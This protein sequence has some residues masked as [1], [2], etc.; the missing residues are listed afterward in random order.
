MA[1]EHGGS[2]RRE[3]LVASHTPDAI[4]ARLA[5]DPRRSYLGDAV[6]GAIDGCVTTFAIVAG[7]MGAAFPGFVVVVLG[8]ANLVADG[9]SMGVSNYQRMKTERESLER[10]RGEEE[11]HIRHYPEGEREEIRQIFAN[12]G[13]RG[14]TLERVVEGITRDR[15]TWV[16]T[17]LTEERGLQPEGASPTWAGMV[18]FGALLIAGL[19][20]LLPFLFPPEVAP[21]RFALSAAMTGVAFFAIGAMRGLWLERSS[22]RAGFET[23]FMGGGAAALAFAV[24]WLLRGF[25]TNA[26]L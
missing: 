2:E 5:G 10:A 4:R 19:I 15:G 11:D 16:N 24:A 23:L 25:I 8:A 6:L 1:H 18:T 20:P 21:N 26:G 13:F 22:V 7:A 3:R 12:K 9:F 14:D 17:M